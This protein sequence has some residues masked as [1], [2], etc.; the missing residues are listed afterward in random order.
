MPIATTPTRTTQPFNNELSL[1]MEL[2]DKTWR[3]FHG[4][5]LSNLGITRRFCSNSGCL[6]IFQFMAGL[7]KRLS[8]ETNEISDLVILSQFFT[9]V[10]PI[11]YHDIKDKL[12]FY[13][14]IVT[15]YCKLSCAE[16]SLFTDT[17]VIDFFSWFQVPPKCHRVG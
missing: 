6:P 11:D 16:A 13:R 3:I 5:N 9:L 12:I 7:G 14:T 1:R 15:N 10:R 8:N 17:F 4:L 2:L